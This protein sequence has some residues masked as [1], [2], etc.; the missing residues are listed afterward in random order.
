MPQPQFWEFL[1]QQDGDRA[2]LPIEAPT[3]EIL[4]GR[5]R[6][7]ARSSLKDTT[8]QVLVVYDA[9]Y[10]EPPVRRMQKRSRQT[11]PNGLLVVAPYTQLK[12]GRWTFICAGQGWK[13]AI[14]IETLQ[15]AHTDLEPDWDLEATEVPVTP[16]LTSSI[17][18][19]ERVAEPASAPAEQP[20]EAAAVL[21]HHAQLSGEMADEVLSEYDL[22]PSQEL[23]LP[24]PTP[25]VA[26]ELSPLA[27]ALEQDNFVARRGDT[28]VLSGEIAPTNTATTSRLH[29]AVVK[30]ILRDPQT[31]KVLLET[32]ESMRD[33]DLP[34]DLT[35]WVTI[36]ATLST[37]LV[38]G[39]ILLQDLTSPEPQ[40]LA[41]QSFTLTADLAELL[42]TIAEQRT[43]APDVM[44]DKVVSET[45]ETG[46]FE[47]LNLTF[48]DFVDTAKP[49]Q[50]RPLDSAAER[51]IPPL[52]ATPVGRTFL[53][54]PD[55]SVRSDVAAEPSEDPIPE[56]P[57]AETAGIESLGDESVDE[58]SRVEPPIASELPPEPEDAPLQDR[59]VDR[60]N[61]LAEDID[62][63]QPPEEDVLDI[64]EFSEED[65]LTPSE[66]L[67]YKDANPA[68]YEFVVDDEPIVPIAQLA[69]A[70]K[71]KSQPEVEVANPFLI[72]EHQPIPTPTLELAKSEL[73]AG[74][75]VQ[76][77][78]KLPDLRPKLY[79]KLWISDRQTRAMLEEPRW[80]VDF[81]PNGF[82][83]IETITPLQ[84]PL[85]S[86]EIEIEAIAVEMASQRQS[87]KVTLERSVITA[88]TS[89]IGPNLA[90]D[91]FS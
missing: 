66:M 60:L 15:Q 83:Q 44:T 54:L 45:I 55:F 67:L 88:D 74:E 78:V 8:V 61:S 11:N 32:E 31:S 23:V 21:H 76:V 56:A 13:K 5:Y 82:D 1:I 63:T 30:V 64:P 81:M 9:L 39:E 37:R 43:I 28:I 18:P 27:I 36:P 3:V 22:L 79:V 47:S 84:V 40:L 16:T 87:R 12:S 75:L 50:P 65:W 7:A 38:L 26:Q 52:L 85:G 80:L 29:H 34:T 41:T 35:Y 90:I 48:L 19:P 17:A 46:Q 14:Q 69:I 57:T 42:E 53:D 6:I 20:V 86:M 58:F 4:E 77:R 62:Q 68:L 73:T 33:Q 71:P 2:W 10:E 91:D 89:D 59:F 72:P 25:L 24:E 49:V 51:A 70:R